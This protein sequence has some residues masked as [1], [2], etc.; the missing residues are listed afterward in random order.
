MP[1]RPA[2]AAMIMISGFLLLLS[3]AILPI[4]LGLSTELN[5]LAVKSKATGTFWQLSADS[6]PIIGSFIE[7]TKITELIESGSAQI[8]KLLLSFAGAT[9]EFLIMFSFNAF[10]M[11]FSAYFFFVHGERILNDL[12]R[13][14]VH[15]G[16]TEWINSLA[17]A[18]TTVRGV[19]HGL[20]LTAFAQAAL[21]S[22]GFYFCGAPSPAI[23]GFATFLLSFIPF[24]TP[25][26]YV[27]ASAFLILH[28]EEFIA[29][30]AL[31][32]WGV[33]I[34]STVDN[35]LRTIFISQ[36]IKLPIL[37]VFI[38]IVGGLLSLGAIGLFIGP[39]LI[40][41]ALSTYQTLLSRAKN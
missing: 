4:V 39:I 11:L 5:K 18:G 34:V 1:N 25:I 6:I 21:A 29:G 37:L 26:V 19:T 15:Y 2:L 30:T 22:L 38:A 9:T 28:R 17:L 32:L 16:Y 13:I 23:L 35:F 33:L 27:P 24:G 40:A 3:L 7:P 14:L 8:G 20:L 12:R 10:L 41:L 31:L 36:S